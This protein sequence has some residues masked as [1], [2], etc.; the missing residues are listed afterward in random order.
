[1]N[2]KN[3]EG[4]LICPRCKSDNVKK[5]TPIYPGWWMNGIYYSSPRIVCLNCKYEFGAEA[6]VIWEK[7]EKDEK[8]FESIKKK[9]IIEEAGGERKEFTNIWF[10]RI[11]ILIYASEFLLP[12][13]SL[14]IYLYIRTL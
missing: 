9:I 3:R 12:L 8:E 2:N 5:A 4:G 10:A 11:I 7:G 1:M 14:L 13:L 6:E